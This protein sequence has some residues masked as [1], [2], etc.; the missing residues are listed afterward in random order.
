MTKIDVVLAPWDECMHYFPECISRD[1]I[2]TINDSV[3]LSGTNLDSR[4]INGVYACYLEGIFC[5]FYLDNILYVFFDNLLIV[6]DEIMSINWR[7]DGCGRRIEINLLNRRS[8]VF[9]YQGL[10]GFFI[11]PMRFIKEVIFAS[12]WFGLTSDL[13]SNLHS[14]FTMN[15]KKS[16]SEIINKINDQRGFVLTNK[17]KVSEELKNDQ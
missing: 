5:V 4:L 13:P 17:K 14:A 10:R 6:Y 2:L 11:N 9:N 1:V 7:S 15:D 8:F 16:F 3:K 12:D